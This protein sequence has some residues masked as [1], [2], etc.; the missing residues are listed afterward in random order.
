[1]IPMGL[2]FLKISKGNLNSQRDRAEMYTNTHYLLIFS[3]KYHYPYNELLI[4]CESATLL[5]GLEVQLLTV[6]SSAY[7]QQ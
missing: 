1:M 4:F 5:L 6:N 7:S 2:Q 3:I